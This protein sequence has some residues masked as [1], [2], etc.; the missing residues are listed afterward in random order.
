MY[1]VRPA[2]L[3]VAWPSFWWFDTYAEFFLDLGARV[4]EVV[5]DECVRI[6]DLRSLTGPKANPG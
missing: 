4:P 6:F 3:A 2:Y 5:R 1:K